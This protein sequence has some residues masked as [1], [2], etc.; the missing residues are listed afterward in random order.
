M[1]IMSYLSKKSKVSSDKDDEKPIEVKND[2]LLYPEED[3]QQTE[4]VL[5]ETDVEPE[6][7]TK[8]E[9]QEKV[10]TENDIIEEIH[11]SFMTEV[12]MLLANAKVMRSM[13]SEKQGLIE[14]AKRL[15]KLGFYQSPEVKEA[16]SE[17]V[18]LEAIQKENEE[19]QQLADA[20]EYFSNKYINFKFIT[21]ESIKRI[22]A[23]YNLI[24][25]GVA[26]FKG[27]VPDD[28]LKRI[29]EANID[30]IDE[31]FTVTEGRTK[32]E[33]TFK[34]FRE[35]HKELAKLNMPLIFGHSYNYRGKDIVLNKE[36]LIIVAPERDF[37]MRGMEVRD[38]ER[39]EKP[40]PK[41]PVVCHPVQFKGRKAFL[42]ITAWGKEASDPDVVNERMN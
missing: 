2:I 41:D 33:I 25:S 15:K 4:E 31:I 24:Y 14:K 29:E 12:D 13:E 30:P 17:I 32:R 22:C 19:N 40:A 27:V 3:E 26:H 11:Q 20:I 36:N 35:Y 7:E 16:E 18:R 37:D 1:G 42:I 23:E 9:T 5:V 10:K 6:E 8:A 38:F 28:N 21:I 39:V 34:Q